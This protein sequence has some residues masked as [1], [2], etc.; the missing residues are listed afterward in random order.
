M[1][2]WSAKP[3]LGPIAPPGVYEIELTVDDQR[4][5]TSIEVKKDP[6]IEISDEIIK[7]QFDF[8]MDIMKQTDLANKSVM[9]IRS[10]KNQ[11]NE[12]S[13]KS[14]LAKSKK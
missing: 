8:A 5:K 2:I 10:I 3:S 13:S 9:K 11:L 14:S 12:I 4:F 6:R 1:I 7:K